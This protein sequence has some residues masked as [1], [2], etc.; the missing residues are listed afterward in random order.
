MPDRN[1]LRHDDLPVDPAF[2]AA[3][4]RAFGSVTLSTEQQRLHLQRMDAAALLVISRTGTARDAGTN[5][6]AGNRDDLRYTDIA[7]W[8]EPA[9]PA[10][11]AAQRWAPELAKVAAAIL[12]CVLVGGLL[13]IVLRDREQEQAIEPTPTIVPNATPTAAPSPTTTTQAVA[14]PT[15]APTSATTPA[16]PTLPATTIVASVSHGQF[17]ANLIWV[18]V[19]G[20]E[21][22][23]PDDSG[24]LHRINPADGEVGQM[25]AI[26]ALPL[27]EDVVARH[28][29]IAGG[30][31]EVWVAGWFGTSEQDATGRLMRVDPATAGI[32]QT[33]D[34]DFLP[35]DVEVSGDTVWL[36][37]RADELVGIDIAS[38]AVMARTQLSATGTL[39]AGAGAVWVTDAIAQE[40][41]RVDPVTG[42]VVT[43]IAIPGEASDLAVA[44][45]ALWVTDRSAGAI[46]RVDSATNAIVATIPAVMPTTIETDGD[47]VWFVE[48]EIPG[49]ISRIDTATN[50]IDFRAALQSADTEAGIAAGGGR[51]WVL[52]TGGALMEI[53]PDE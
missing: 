45:D 24:D 44:G 33:I 13:V 17:L 43:R 40:V 10:R 1:N 5:N 22:W 42:Q 15:I 37:S 25:V 6:G 48:F 41:V 2:D 16:P 51:V 14:S 11:R 26:D 30:G 12:A 52:N 46:Y 20:G 8:R 29:F 36:L 53:L 38:G 32:A 35:R 34:L 49:R 21:L 28:L 50:T 23:I 9:S 47:K 4:R 27:T 18:D 39:V 19:N 7:S 31:A 3:L